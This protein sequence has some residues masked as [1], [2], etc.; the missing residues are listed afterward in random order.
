MSLGISVH[1]EWRNTKISAR[2]ILTKDVDVSIVELTS[3][4]YDVTIFGQPADLLRIAD[5]IVQH[6]QDMV[7]T[8]VH[9]PGCL[10]GSPDCPESAIVSIVQ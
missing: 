9:K 5:A 3:D 7:V 1:P 2:H 8:T 6:C 4:G 10:C